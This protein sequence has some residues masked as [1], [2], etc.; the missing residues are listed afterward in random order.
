MKFK[1]SFFIRL[2]KLIPIIVLGAS[3]SAFLYFIFGLDSYNS[4]LNIPYKISEYKRFYIY[5][6]YF[7]FILFFDAVNKKNNIHVLYAF[8]L[9][10]S[11]SKLILLLTILI[12]CYKY[13]NKNLSLNNYLYLV[14]I[15]FTLTYVAVFLG[16]FERFFFLYQYGDPWRIMEPINALKRLL[17]PVKFFIGNGAGIPYSDGVVDNS[18]FLS[19]YRL[20]E[21]S[22]FDVHNGI[23]TLWLKFGVPMGTFFLYK[24][25][26]F[27]PMIPNKNFLFFLLFALIFFSHGPIQTIEALG[28]VLGIRLLDFKNNPSITGK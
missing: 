25:Y 19:N 4:T 13:L 22:R 12:Y 21:N 28:L 18:I 6:F 14:G 8:L 24:C 1:P 7:F 17:H 15:L 23:V 20:Q 10:L 27:V 3:A 2:E 16:I 11:G 26:K 9:I 5:P